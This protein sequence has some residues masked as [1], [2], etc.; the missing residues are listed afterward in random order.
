MN[1]IWPGLFTGLSLIVAI[2]AQNAFVLR[3]GLT[4]RHIFAVVFICSLSDALLITLGTA[5]L[6]ALIQSAPLLLEILR[7]LGVAYLSW[8]G[9]SAIRKVVGKDTL[10]VGEEN[11]LPLRQT[12]L[13]TLGF[14]FLNPHV[15]LDTVILV[16][17]LA[18][19]FANERWYFALGAVAASFIW[20]FSLGF[21]AGKMAVLMARPAF[22]KILDVF[23]AA[24]M[25][26]LAINLALGRL[27]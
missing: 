1:A 8:F 24:V 18:N 21:V 14:T 12:V 23:I 17:G 13:L 2:G 5:G 22:W 20:F 19:Q 7:W 16:G 4:R 11:A 10:Q 27:A 9:I 3:Q 15:Y 25:F 6:G 26:S